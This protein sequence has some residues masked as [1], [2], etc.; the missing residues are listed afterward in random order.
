MNMLSNTLRRTPWSTA[1]PLAGSG[2]RPVFFI[3]AGIVLAA[4]LS[5]AQTPSGPILRLTATTE[6][7]VGAHDSI[8]IDVLRWSTDAER[9]QLLSAWT[10]P[11]APA[12][13][14]RVGRGRGGAAGNELPPGAGRGGRGGGRGSSG[15]APTA[16]PTPE[17]SLKAALDK[18]PTVGYLWSSEV[19]GYSLRYAI[20][21]PEQDGGERIIFVTDR[22]LGDSNNLWKPAGPGSTADSATNY[23][24]SLIELRLNAKGEG[25]G[26]IS[27]PGKVTVDTAAKT[28]V[29]ENYKELPVVLKNVRRR[30][31]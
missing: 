8:R 14:G 10:N 28:F 26:K 30:T 27:L 21:L 19:T 23:E 25:E 17:S 18:A 11:A 6:N 2:V 7:V 31:N 1:G 29:L 4:M 20:R 13:S 15:G 3:S 12:A 16:P 9:D 24:F 5:T 22:R